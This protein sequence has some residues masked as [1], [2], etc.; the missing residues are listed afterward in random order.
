MPKRKRSQR[1]SDAVAAKQLRIVT[2]A[3]DNRAGMAGEE[4]QEPYKSDATLFSL[5]N[6]CFYAIF[7]RLS[8]NDLCS[9]SE[10]CQRLQ[11]LS[12][13]HFSRRYTS[14]VLMIDNVTDSGH[15]IKGPTGE[16][17][18]NCFALSSRTV[19][20]GQKLGSKAGLK[21]LERYYRANKEEMEPIKN[22]RIDHWTRGLMVNYGQIIHDM[23]K[24]V[25]SF[26]LSNTD[27][28]GDLHTCILNSLP[29]L[30]RFT[31]WK[32]DRINNE[33]THEWLQQTY[34]NLQYFAWHAASELQIDL[35]QFFFHNNPRITFFSL[36]SCSQNTLRHLFERKIRVNEL[37]FTVT[38]SPGVF[39]DLLNLC[40]QQGTRLHLK[41]PDG[42]PRNVLN[43]NM[44]QFARLHQ[45]VDGLY[46]QNAGIQNNLARALHTF[47]HL[48]ILQLNIT[49]TDPGYRFFDIAPLQEIY[50]F[51]GVCTQTFRQYRAAMMLFA[52]RLPRLKRF[53]MR[54]NSQPFDRFEFGEMDEA[55]KRLPGACKL[56]IHVRSDELSYMG[57]LN[58]IQREYDTIA[59]ERVETEQVKNPLV[60]EFLIGEKLKESNVGRS[61]RRHRWY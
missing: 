28:H 60:T 58:D 29:K 38:G 36:Q 47:S 23:I 39:V 19:S 18:V 56:K 34:P 57:A 49:S 9:V 20:L 40:Q 52:R 12:S 11:E 42:T 45:Y 31:F 51:Y 27:V 50:A 43:Q 61:R 33:M 14:K 21:R 44:D 7:N 17:Y 30:N 53:Y 16:K 25:E 13:D 59:I 48:K 2:T 22:L 15:L 5:N 32:K 35:A 4:E 10:T 26:T 41:F 24:D 8:L 54:N 1:I 37:F 6:D 46:F 55:R 3:D